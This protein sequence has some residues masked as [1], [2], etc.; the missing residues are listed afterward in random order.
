MDHLPQEE[1]LCFFCLILRVT[2]IGN[3]DAPKYDVT[4]VHPSTH[5]VVDPNI[6]QPSTLV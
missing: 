6:R 1:F 4:K 3:W 5:K 2:A